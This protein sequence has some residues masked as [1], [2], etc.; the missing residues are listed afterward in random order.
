MARLHRGLRAGLPEESALAAAQR[1][2]L[3]RP[4]TA[5]PFYWAGL[6][7]VGSR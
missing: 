7:L 3:R 5:D 6:V 4:E 1:E 2:A